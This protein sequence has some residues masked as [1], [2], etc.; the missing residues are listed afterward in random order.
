ML[1]LVRRLAILSAICVAFHS[2]P[3]SAQS[4][5]AQSQPSSPRSTDQ[6]TPQN[7]AAIPQTTPPPSSA[8]PP[9]PAQQPGTV[10][11]QAAPPS[12]TA[13][14][15]VPAPADQATPAQ[16]PST[17]A[18]SAPD[19]NSAPPAKHPKAAKKDNDKPIAQADIHNASLW[20]DPGSIADKDMFYGAGGKD[21]QPVPPFKF[22]EEDM[23]GTNPKADVEDANGK[24]WRMK[25][26]E[27]A[28][29]EVVA[30]RLLW[31][32]GYYVNDDYLIHVATVQG[33][34]NMKRGAKRIHN[35]E[36]VIDARFARKPGKDTKVG[37]WEWKNNPFRDTREF[38]G[39]RVMMAV[40]NSW[41]LKDV[42][43]A[44]YTNKKTGR[45]IFLVSDI[46]ATFATNTLETHRSQDKGNVKNYVDS[47]FITK[48]TATTVDFGTPGAPTGA[49]I[50]SGG[51]LAADY[52]K[53]KG[54]EW[55]GQNIPRE[56][57]RWVGSMLGQLSH[58]QLVDAFRAGNFQPESIDQYV[59]VLESR[60]AQLK[61]L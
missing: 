15:E 21:G 51:I 42:N 1:H 30:S 41:D 29:P 39:L 36:Q 59:S 44:V 34:D 54:F 12:S 53:R 33:L 6:S 20:R 25:L 4:Q 38:N 28:R 13:P 46:G 14:Q 43:N 16:P 47:K 23:N 19:S 32:V 35:G 45:Q 60:I 18:T 31:A 61:A 56:D 55:I 9:Q 40:L 7:P 26:G 49:L 17:P 24:K 11:E 52:V 37:I 3:F 2:A 5:P 27:E 58:Q 57:A 50:K 48:T 10:P 8:A 22:L